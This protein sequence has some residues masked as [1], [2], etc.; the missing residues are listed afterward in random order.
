MGEG[1]GRVEARLTAFAEKL[2]EFSGV[3]AVAAGTVNS[4]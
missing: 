2:R 3:S 1:N 4:T